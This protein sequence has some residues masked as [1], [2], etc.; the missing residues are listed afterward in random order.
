[1][2]T[3]AHSC[4]SNVKSIIVCTLELVHQVGG[5]AV[6]EYGNGIGDVDVSE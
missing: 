2:R 6:S 3:G 5:F 4:M 1:M